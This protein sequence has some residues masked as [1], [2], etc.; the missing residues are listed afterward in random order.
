MGTVIN[1]KLPQRQMV[2]KVKG[3]TFHLPLPLQETLYKL[4]SIT[5]PIDMNP[6]FY[7]LIRSI[8]TKSKIIWKEIVDVKKVFDALM[9]LKRNN[10]LYSHIILPN[11]YS[12]LC[13][14]K[15]KSSEFLMEEENNTETSNDELE[16]KNK[17]VDETKNDMEVVLEN[18]QQKA[19]LTQVTD[20]DLLFISRTND[21]RSIK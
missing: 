15:L 16:V 12:E 6:E 9:W 7:I 1:K 3:R 17:S 8:P 18:Q 10:A 11:N 20:E 13:L 5:D 14:P 21:E 19:M 4:C 2:Q